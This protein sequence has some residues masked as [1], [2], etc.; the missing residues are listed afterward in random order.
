M[1]F[2]YHKNVSSCLFFREGL[3]PAGIPAHVISEPVISSS[4]LGVSGATDPGGST[5]SLL[6]ATSPV[7]SAARMTDCVTTDYRWYDNA[8]SECWEEGDIVCTSVHSITF[9]THEELD[10]QNID[11]YT[12]VNNVHRYSGSWRMDGATI[13]APLLRCEKTR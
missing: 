8:K 9:C 12:V 10:W 4:P 11:E 13:M 2:R 5:I 1:R 6:G 7:R 3:L